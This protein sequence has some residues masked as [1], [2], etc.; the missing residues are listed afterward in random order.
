MNL[1][2]FA[3][4]VS[5]SFLSAKSAMQISQFI[6][7]GALKELRLLRKSPQKY[8]YFFYLQIFWTKNNSRVAET[9]P[10]N[11]TERTFIGLGVLDYHPDTYSVWNDFHSPAKS[12]SAV[13]PTP[14]SASSRVR[15]INLASIWNE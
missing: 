4:K 2:N 15:F 13:K 10:A 6:N 9:P 8:T 7:K 14:V 3:A 11:R 1:K 5:Q 12:K